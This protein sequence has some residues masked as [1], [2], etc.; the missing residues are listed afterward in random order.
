MTLNTDGPTGLGAGD[1]PVLDDT[2]LD[3]GALSDTDY[4][5]KLGYKQ[6]LNRA[7]G[8]FS[9]FGVQFSSIA[10]GSAMYTTVIV[11]I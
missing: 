2:T 9:S 7:L 6:E 8:L 3:S 1:Q 11:G 4:L 10:V 5:A